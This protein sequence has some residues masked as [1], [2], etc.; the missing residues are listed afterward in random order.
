MPYFLSRSRDQLINEV[1]TTFPGSSVLDTDR[2]C[3]EVPFCLSSGLAVT[4]LV[5][6]PPSFPRAA[7]IIFL[8]P[9]LDHPWVEQGTGKASPPLL[10]SWPSPDV[11]LASLI[12]QLITGV[13]SK[14][15]SYSS[16]QSQTQRRSPSPTKSRGSLF[17]MRLP[18][19][20]GDKGEESKRGDTNHPGPSSG[21]GGSFPQLSAMSTAELEKA[22]LDQ[23]AFDL[24]L[25]IVATES[26]GATGAL[27]QVDN[28]RQSNILLARSNLAKEAEMEEVRRQIAIVRSTSYE[29]AKVAFEEKL[30]R[31][32]AAREHI[33]PEKLIER[34]S[35]ASMEA[36]REANALEQ[37]FRAGNLPLDRFIEAYADAKKKYHAREL[38]YQAALQTIPSALTPGSTSGLSR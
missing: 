36:N 23:S 27:A 26:R 31:Q 3:L 2:S 7:P 14:L 24:L 30:R 12:Q 37:Q 11:R 17:A 29:P 25:K 6:L 13:D 21:F 18:F 38:K 20:G 4:L 32:E 5:T 15:F 9:P 10:N 28:L 22:M 34:L 19:F 33:A 35:T 1:S 16:P 8:N